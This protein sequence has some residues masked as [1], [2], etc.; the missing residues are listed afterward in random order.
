MSMAWPFKAMAKICQA[1]N[2]DE[3]NRGHVLQCQSS[4]AHP[5]IWPCSFFDWEGAQGTCSIMHVSHDNCQSA[6]GNSSEP[7]TI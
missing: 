6:T 5:K 7:V 2:G 4:P 3:G 1:G